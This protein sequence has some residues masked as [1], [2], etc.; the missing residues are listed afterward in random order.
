MKTFKTP[1][2][3]V[4]V[5]PLGHA[6]IQILW[7]GKYI[8]VDP[9]SEVMEFTGMPKAD[10][11]LISHNHYDHLDIYAIRPIQKDETVFVTDKYSKDTIKNANTISP[12]EEFIFEGISIKAF[13]AYNIKNR[14][15]DGVPFH[16]LGEVNGYILNFNGFKI[17]IAGDT[18]FI[19]EMKDLKHV[20]LAF[21]PK[22]LPYT[23]TDD[24]FID[25]ANAIA[26]MYLYAYHYFDIDTEYL[27]RGLKPT[28]ELLN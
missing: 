4:T 13:P 3:D 18:E 24:E 15:D 27:R 23:M 16:S 2:G 26:P 9:Y 20:D 21:L 19:H 22:N 11:I 25:A 1:L 6:S 7:N 10:L 8:Y 5:T 12:G 28:I 14:R 17:Y